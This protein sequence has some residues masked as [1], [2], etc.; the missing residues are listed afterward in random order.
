MSSNYCAVA[1]ASYACNPE[2]SKGRIYKEPESTNRAEFQRDRDRIIHSGAFRRLKHKT[3]VFVAHE[4]DDYRT[5]LT[6]SIEVAQVARSLARS[7]MVNE[8]LAEAVALAHD[9]GHAPFSHMGEEYL[10]EAMKDYG[11]FDHN[12]QSL[13]ILTTVEN[14]YPKFRGLNLCWET[15][16]GV[17]KHNGPVVGNGK[18]NNLHIA[19]KQLQEKTDLRLDTHAS[20]EAQV[21]A[22]SDDIAYNS[23]DM[24]DGIKSGM[25]GLDDLRDIPLVNRVI[26]K[27]ERNYPDIEENIKNHEVIREIMG[28]LIEDVMTETKR[29]LSNIKPE[30]SDDVRMAGLQI[31]DFSKE[32]NEELNELRKFLFKRMY[33]HYTINRICVKVERII[34]DLFNA[35][36]HTD[37]QILPDKWQARIE[38][39]GIYDEAG[40]ARIICDYIAGMTDRYAIREHEKLFDLYWDMKK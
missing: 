30:T 40:K 20:M 15:L 31:V 12:D 32:M 18:D 2:E 7:L 23:H 29:N 5:R 36:M 11:G 26:E 16:E 21:A 24:Q 6:H 1:L 22:I 3:Q 28:V 19:C 17:V 33:K 14:K 27:V 10:R 9:L 38:E 34:T 4:G 8:D 13:R 25:F 37:Y 39:V 35:F